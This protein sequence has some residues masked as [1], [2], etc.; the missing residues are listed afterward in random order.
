MNNQNIGSQGGQNQQRGSSNV[1]GQQSAQK[2]DLNKDKKNP[3]GSSS[4]GSSS[5]Y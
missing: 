4:T 1:G 2:T 3:S 5:K